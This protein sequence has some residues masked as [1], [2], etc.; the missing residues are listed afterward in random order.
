MLDV[1]SNGRL[2]IGVGKG[3]TAFEHLQFGHP[4]EEASARADDTLKLLLRAW[5]PES[6]RATDRS[7]SSSWR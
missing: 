6:C 4:A 3:I 2:E 1:I 5:E 7:S